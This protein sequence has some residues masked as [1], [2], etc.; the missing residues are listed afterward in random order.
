MTDMKVN[1]PGKTD[2]STKTSKTGSKQ[3]TGDNSFGTM[4]SGFSGGAEK[5]DGVSGMS[6]AQKL[7]SLLALQE[8]ADS[9]SEEAAKRGRKRA[10][11]LLDYLENI[12]VGILTGGIPK[13]ALEELSRVVAA[14][15]DHIMDPYLADILDEIDLRAQVE[16]AKHGKL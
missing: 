14:K 16:L 15:K 4:V 13:Q 3:K 5:A 10:E 8:S 6:S 12:R 11:E 2:K 9:A 7:D 1:G